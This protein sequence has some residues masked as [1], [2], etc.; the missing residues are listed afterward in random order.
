LLTE[1]SKYK[2]L[3]LEKTHRNE[4][5]FNRFL[6]LLKELIT[7]IPKKEITPFM[8]DANK[9]SP[10]PKDIIYLALAIAIKANIWSNDKNLKQ[11]QTRINV[12]SIEDLLKKTGFI[13]S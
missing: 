4:E 1:F 8:D 11:S 6:E 5:D 12:F 2:D 13:K 9:I 10:D 3:I 7:I